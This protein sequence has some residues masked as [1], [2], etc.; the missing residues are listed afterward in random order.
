[1]TDES[2]NRVVL[3]P[4]RATYAGGRSVSTGRTRIEWSPRD[5]V[6]ATESGRMLEVGDT[7]T[8]AD[9]LLCAIPEASVLAFARH[10]SPVTE[11]PRLAFP[12]LSA[13]ASA[14]FGW[15]P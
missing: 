1:M 12:V 9:G 3:V 11:F 15:L 7:F 5:L 8:K 10:R 4:E 14:L 6:L 2:V 13:L